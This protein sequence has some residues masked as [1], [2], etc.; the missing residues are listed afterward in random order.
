VGGLAVTRVGRTLSI[1]IGGR[2]LVPLDLPPEGPAERIGCSYALAL[3][4]TGWTVEGGPRELSETGDLDA[5]PKVTGLFSELDLR[6]EGAPTIELV[7]TIHATRTTTLQAV[8]WLGAAIAALL[9]L[10]LVTRSAR[11]G[12]PWPA[13]IRSLGDAATHARP[14][15][16]VVAVLL[17]AW[18]VLSPVFYDDGWVLVRQRNFADSGGFSAYYSS[19]GVNLPLDY[20]LEWVEHWLFQSTSSVLVLRLPALGALAATWVICRWI[21][22]RALASSGGHDRY[23]LLALGAAFAVGAMAWGMTLRPEPVLALLVAGVLACT[24]RFAE[25]ETTGPPALAAVLVV[26]A[27]AAHP[28]GIAALAPLAVAGPRLVRWARP[29]LAIVATIVLA[30]LSLL[31][32]L[33]VVGSDAEQ[34]R[35]DTQSL[36]AYGDEVAG[37][38][39]ELDRY[40]LLSQAP[41]G[42]ALRR[43][44]VALILLAVLGYLLRR[45]AARRNV[46]LDLPS[47]AL[48]VSLVLFLATPSKWPWHFG[49]LIGLA[50]VAVATET[51]RLVENARESRGWDA[52]PLI[53]VGAAALAAAWSWFP[54]LHWNALDL[55]TLDWTLGIESRVTLA[56]IA[57]AAPVV[58]LAGL[59]LFGLLRRR[60]NLALAPWRAAALTAPVVALPLIV[61]TVGVLAAD[62]AKTSSWTLG[63]QNLESLT[64]GAGCGVADD[65]LVP[66]LGSMRALAAAGDDATENRALAPAPVQ[67]VRRFTLGPAPSTTA[68]ARSAWFVLPPS[69]R[70]GFFLTGAPG[71]EDALEIEWGRRSG[72]RVSPI[73]RDRV[74][75]DVAGGLSPKLVPWRF[76]P[77]GQ[78]PAA[79]PEAGAVRFVLG[80]RVVPSGQVA[81]TSPVTY[82]N[83][84]LAD[85]LRSQTP[86]AL[87]LPDLVLYVPCAGQPEVSQGSAESPGVVLGFTHTLWPIGSGT[88]PFDGVADVHQLTALPLTDSAEPPRGLI[89][90]VADLSAPGAAL[91]PPERELLVS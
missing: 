31:A 38:R 59:L 81:L 78:L 46:L 33:A 19:F 70:F 30:S 87:I 56:K 62:T 26:L 23:A 88:S 64:S 24:V 66:V 18:W 32:T 67:A 45:R 11:G 65:A 74:S 22:R 37:W 75:V 85:L 34:R 63:R 51:R 90:Y 53:V 16:A 29:R 52:R 42:A 25:R 79:P 5:M 76:Y 84:P 10:L 44:S 57:G 17:L 43:A 13:L 73:R 15:D 2:L 40:S 20:W 4:A 50:A 1:S 77:A 68:P 71:A 28:A 55:R 3:S 49:A 86:P 60:H 61:F 82:R 89:A 27:L 47:A 7:S 39:G 69:G 14:I 91:A 54:R 58:L 72:D 6:A 83:Q 48:G 12:R 80:S 21:L 8:A 36:R 41:Y 9:S 35:A